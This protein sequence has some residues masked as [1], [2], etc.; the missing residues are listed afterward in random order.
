MRRACFNCGQVYRTTTE[1]VYA[2]S[3]SNPRDRTVEGDETCSDRCTIAATV[4]MGTERGARA[5]G[6]AAGRAARGFIDGVRR[7]AQ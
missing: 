3:N 7:H 6:D 4:K 1:Y 2:S 5:V